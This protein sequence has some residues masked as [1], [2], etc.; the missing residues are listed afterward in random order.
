MNNSPLTISTMANGLVGSEIIKIANEVNEMKKNGKEICNLTIGDFDPTYYPIPEVL[1]KG[2]VDA[3]RQ[4]LTNYPPAHGLLN[5]RQSVSSFIKDN[6]NIAYQPEDILIAGGSR[7]LI[8]AAYLALIDHGD[9]VIYPA[10]SWNNNH[11]C[12]LSSARGIAI[13]TTADNHFMPTPEE[14][15]PHLKDATLLALC[16]PLNPT[17][18]VFTK[19]GL[20]DICELVLAE[21]KTRAYNQKPLYILYDQVYWQLTFGDTQHFDPVSLVPELK[22]YVIYIDGISKSFAATGVRVGWAFGPEMVM[23][24]MRS[25]L[26][27]IGA[28][29]PKAEQHATAKFL[30]NREAVNAFM[31]TFKT[32]IETSLDNLYKGINAMSSDTLDVEAIVP[33]GAIYLTAKFEVLGKTTPA[34]DI[35]ITNKDVAFYI[36]KEANLAIVPFSAFGTS[37]SSC[38]FRLSVGACSS[39]EIQSALPRLKAALEKL[40]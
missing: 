33:M 8:Y 22:D 5:L 17:G 38:W 11:Y 4:G 15:K 25:I 27:H 12:H 32:K 23:R 13:E 21:N 9:T 39:E 28:W 19:Q 37:D 6:L 29:A 2:I 35:L 10:P 16:S 24:K 36:L 31:E 30:E 40:K 14:L 3:Y 20:K 26:G 7:P 1:E 34:G 18:T